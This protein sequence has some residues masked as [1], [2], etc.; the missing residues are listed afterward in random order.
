[1]ESMST[2]YSGNIVE[3]SKAVAQKA[4]E[5]VEPNWELISARLN[6]RV[7]ASPLSETQ[8]SRMSDVGKGY[9]NDIIKGKSKRPKRD[10]LARIGRVIDT[11]VE[12][13]YGEQDVPRMGK[14]L[15]IPLYKIGIS[16]QD[17]FAN[18]SEDIKSMSILPVPDGSYIVSVPDDAMAP[19]YK[20]GE[21]VIVDPRAPVKSGGFV[22][23]LTNEDRVAIRELVSIDTDKICV[24][25]ISDPTNVELTRD[26]TKALHRIIGSVELG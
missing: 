22:L 16:D 10:A 24:R 3:W 25:S 5:G 7:K 17:G 18:F 12:Y 6:E 11:D 13:F 9:I 2:S 26:G 8:I 14:G 20:S 1:M 4:L 21:G 19:R 23:I 15:R